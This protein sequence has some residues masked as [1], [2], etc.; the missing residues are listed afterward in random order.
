VGKSSITDSPKRNVYLNYYL[1]V[2]RTTQTFS[3]ATSY[4][5][6][7]KILSLT[8]FFVVY[9]TTLLLLQHK[10]NKCCMF[11]VWICSLGCTACNYIFICGPHDTTIFL[12]IFYKGH[13]FLGGRGFIDNKMCVLFPNTEENSEK[14]YRNCTLVFM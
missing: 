12:Y 8:S 9:F 11:L 7:Y 4:N 10:S 14:Y 3:T 13:D 2:E 6:V 1:Y 5:Y